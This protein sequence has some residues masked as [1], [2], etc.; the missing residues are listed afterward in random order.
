MLTINHEYST[1]H[2]VFVSVQARVWNIVLFKPLKLTDQS[3]GAEAPML[4]YQ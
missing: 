1:R 3:I 4:K 2:I